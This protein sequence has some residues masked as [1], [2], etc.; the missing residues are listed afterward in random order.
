MQS[1]QEILET[2]FEKSFEVLLL[3][4]LL[5]KNVLNKPTYEKALKQYQMKGTASYPESWARKI[6]W[7]YKK[8]EEDGKP[9]YWT[10]IRK[11]AGVKKKNFQSVI[12]YLIKHTDAETVE[13]IMVLVTD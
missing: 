13:Q 7:A 12:P 6:I 2:K 9:F 10:D 4:A 3:R 5:K 11:K 8:L 1:G